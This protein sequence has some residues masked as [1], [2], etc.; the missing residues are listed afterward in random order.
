MKVSKVATQNSEVS[1]AIA[2]ELAEKNRIEALVEKKRNEIA[3]ARQ[4]I[5][6]LNRADENA[7]ADKMKGVKETPKKEVL[8]IDPSRAV[9]NKKPQVSDILTKIKIAGLNAS[10]YRY[11]NEDTKEEEETDDSSEV[12]FLKVNF[13]I[14]QNFVVRASDRNYY[15]QVLDDKNNLIGDNVTETIDG[16]KV[17]YCHRTNIKYKNRAVK[18]SENIYIKDLKEGTYTIKVLDRKDVVSQTKVVLN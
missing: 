14:P 6:D 7:I 13:V 10:S 2:K 12:G 1:K 3:K 18:V 16:E 17:T 11:V 4:A 8:S 9:V 15:I 5:S